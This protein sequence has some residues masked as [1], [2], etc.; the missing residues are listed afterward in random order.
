MRPISCGTPI[1][2]SRCVARSMVDHTMAAAAM[3]TGWLPPEQGQAEAG[4]TD[5]GRERIAVLQEVRIG[6]QVR[7]PD[8]PGDGPDMNIVI[9]T[10]FFGLTPAERAA[11]GL[12]PESRSS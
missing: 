11:D 8:H 5:H 12:R 2:T 3:P 4:E 7:Q 10:I 6:E 9:S 1:A